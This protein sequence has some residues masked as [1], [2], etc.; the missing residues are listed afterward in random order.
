MYPYFNICAT[1][2]FTNGENKIINIKLN[3][4]FE[5]ISL[6]II[7]QIFHM[8]Y[9]LAY[10]IHFPDVYAGW[11]SFFVLVQGGTIKLST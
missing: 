3:R 4:T 9:V 7:W 10:Q 11:V 2:N 5:P 1:R 6:E 8:Q